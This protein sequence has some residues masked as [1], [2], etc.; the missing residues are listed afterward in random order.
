MK[1]L[2]KYLELN[3]S[4]DFFYKKQNKDWNINKTVKYNG[5]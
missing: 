2:R 3:N 5:I 1:M 4:K